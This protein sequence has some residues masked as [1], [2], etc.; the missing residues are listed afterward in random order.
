MAGP[1]CGPQRPKQIPP[2]CLWSGAHQL[3][4]FHLPRLLAE[5]QQGQG[6]RQLKAARSCA[7]RVQVEDSCVVALNSLMGVAADDGVERGGLRL[8]VQI[9]EIVKHI[10]MKSSGLD[11]CGE[12]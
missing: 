9:L 1:L 6:H 7:T 11:N 5:F 2:N 3:N 10:K 12:R 4:E 8:E